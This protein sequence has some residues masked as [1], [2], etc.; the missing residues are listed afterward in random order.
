M[1]IILDKTVEF[2]IGNWYRMYPG[3]GWTLLPSN[4]EKILGDQY[5]GCAEVADIMNGNGRALTCI[6][7]G[8]P[9]KEWSP[10]LRESMRKRA[11]RIEAAHR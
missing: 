10:E 5:V 3:H 7:D 9:E 8:H 6:T 4:E 1:T 11:E 2:T